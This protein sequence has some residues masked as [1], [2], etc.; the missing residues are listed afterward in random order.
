MQNA[1]RA[2]TLYRE[3]PF[4]LG[5]DAKEFYPDQKK[6]E[7][8]LIQGIIDAYFEEDGEIIVLDY[9]TDRVQTEAELK[10]RYLE[11]LRD[12]E[13]TMALAYIVQPLEVSVMDGQKSMEELAKL[14]EAQIDSKGLESLF[15]GA[16]VRA[17]L[18]RPRG[19][20]ILACVNRYRM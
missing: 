15:V 6:G 16:D 1:A 8:V 14:I 3:Q 9:K 5:V 13:Q 10:D 20:E 11:Q 17:S 12:T 4:V 19:L 7:M 2:K 18:A